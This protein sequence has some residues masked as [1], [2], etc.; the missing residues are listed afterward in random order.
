LD[1]DT[2]PAVVE[3]MGQAVTLKHQAKLA[4]RTLYGHSCIP[5][6]FQG[7]SPDEAFSMFPSCPEGPISSTRD[8]LFVQTV[9]QAIPALLQLRRE[10]LELLDQIKAAPRSVPALY[11]PDP[12]TGERRKTADCKPRRRRGRQAGSATA[13][14]DL[15]LYTA[16]KA[17][18][19][20]T[21]ITKA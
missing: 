12:T 14:S 20:A 10:L 4:V 18:N 5:P 13:K 17:A 2:P 15:E 16:W 6:S 9:R 3:G 1:T 19:R 11:A 8:K 7:R 21:G